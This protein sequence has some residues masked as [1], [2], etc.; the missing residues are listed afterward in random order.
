[1]Q[2][3]FRKISSKYQF[4]S[5]T[6]VLLAGGLGLLFYVHSLKKDNYQK[7]QYQL[8]ELPLFYAKMLQAEQLF[9]TDEAQTLRFLK[10]KQSKYLDEYEQ[11][12]RR[13]Q[14]NIKYLRQN[15]TVGQLEQHEALLKVEKVL[16][17]YR[18]NILEFA[19]KTKQLGKDDLGMEGMLKKDFEALATIPTLS[20]V[21][22]LGLKQF[23]NEFLLYK[24]VDASKSFKDETYRILDEV[25]QKINIEDSIGRQEMAQTVQALEQCASSMDK[26]VALHQYLGLDAQA[27]LKAKITQYHQD[28]NKHFLSM[29]AQAEAKLTLLVRD[30]E[31]FVW[32]VFIIALLLAMLL[33]LVIARIESTPIVSLA[34]IVQSLRNGIKNQ[35]KLLNHRSFERN[36]EIGSL[37]KH[38]QY[39]IGMIKNTLAQIREKDIQLEKNAQQ[40]L[41]RTWHSEGLTLFRDIFR[42]QYPTQEQQA[43]EIISELVKYTHS[44]QGG[45]FILQHETPP[46]LALTACYAYERQKYKQKN[47]Q[48][49]EGLVGTAWKENK[50]LLISDIPQDYTYIKSALGKASPKALLIIPIK[51]E[52]EVV[53]V[54]ELLALHPYQAHEI[55]FVE[56]L[57]GRIGSALV[58]AQANERNKKLLLAQEQ[59]VEES[60]E[61]ENQL[62]AQIKNYQYWLEAFEKKLKQAIE[63]NEIYQA[64]VNKMYKGM[65]VTN[66]KFRIIMVND[67]ILKRYNHQ[68]QDLMDLPLETL[69]DTDYEYILDLRERKFKLNQHTFEKKLQSK[70][71]DKIGKATLVESISG[72]LEIEDKVVY[73][74]ML[75]ELSAESRETQNNNSTAPK[76]KVAS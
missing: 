40:E 48:L 32:T 24:N 46:S 2:L 76:L 62:Q 59:I 67:Y 36:D 41:L 31:A 50:T 29:Q 12:Y 16:K 74:F 28:L 13:L 20:E 71:I 30:A 55:E 38:F 54:V 43:F 72:K 3:P 69:L 15:P 34:R 1:M 65:I 70:I 23:K 39:F 35:D 11:Q 63:A 75:N 68:A 22:I 9:K 49:G 19:E 5:F 17:E 6:L 56:N 21:Q 7:Y 45:L 26:L 4:Y 61:K 53:G 33:S 14:K 27:G 60:K 8:S 66:E 42:R 52:E 73:I 37:A 10:T 47:I 58:T 44:Q 57:A 18:K 51:L 25:R 64:V